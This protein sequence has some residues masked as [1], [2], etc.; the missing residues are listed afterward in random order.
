MGYTDTEIATWLQPTSWS[1]RSISTVENSVITEPSGEGYA[2]GKGAWPVEFNRGSTIT[3]TGHSWESCGYLN[4][5]KG[6]PA[7]Q[8]GELTDHQR[9]EA[10]TSEQWGGS[11]LATGVTDSR[12]AV[13]ARLVRTDAAGNLLD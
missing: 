13:T 9:F 11:I 3:C 1:K 5:S 4:Y 2:V 6:L 8:A 10:I 12:E 7:F